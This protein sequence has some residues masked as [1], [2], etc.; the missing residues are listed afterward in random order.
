M[1]GKHKKGCRSNKVLAYELHAQTPVDCT[2]NTAIF[3]QQLKTPF[4][5]ETPK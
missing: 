2:H 5:I 4:I 3:N 1:I